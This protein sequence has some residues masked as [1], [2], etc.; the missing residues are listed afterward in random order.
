[1]S[2][3]PLAD[4]AHPMTPADPPS[5]MPPVDRPP[6]PFR[7]LRYF[8]A[9]GVVLLGVLI[10]ATVPGTLGGTICTAVVGIGLIAVVSLIFY[11]IGL[12]EDR[13]RARDR[14]GGVDES[15]S[16]APGHNGAPPRADGRTAPRR[17]HRLRDEHRRSH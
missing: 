16:P 5:S 2:L 14:R 13:D 3:A 4:L 17:P 8:L 12:T 10:G 11:D 15:V 1:M 9:I 6:D 7:P